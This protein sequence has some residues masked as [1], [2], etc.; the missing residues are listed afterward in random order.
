MKYHLVLITLL[1]G[2]VACGDS[3]TRS[4]FVASP[5]AIEAAVEDFAIPAT[6]SP[7]IVSPEI[8]SAEPFSQQFDHSEITEASGLQRSL[9]SDGVYYTHNDSGGDAVLFAVDAYGHNIGTLRLNGVQAQ[10]WEAIGAARL[11]GEPTLVIGDIG[12]N[13]RQRENVRLLLVKEPDLNRLSAGFE[14]TVVAESLPLN[15]ADGLAYDAESLF[16][17]T[18]NDTL[19]VITKNFD[20]PRVQAVWT[21]SLALGLREGAVVL[22]FGGLVLLDDAGRAGAITGADLHPGGSELAVLAYGPLSTGRVHLWTIGVNERAA[23]VVTR[24]ADRVVD[25]P[26]SVANIQAEGVSY[27]ADGK[28]ILISAESISTSTLSVVSLNR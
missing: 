24:P 1:S 8:N 17:D 20:D 5:S 4:S 14:E 25:I 3:S 12:D 23:T 26:L 28:H 19:V 13:S 6:D 10:D 22:D 2:L 16:V 7:A 27:S 21:G 9:W 15:Y 11:N 18:D